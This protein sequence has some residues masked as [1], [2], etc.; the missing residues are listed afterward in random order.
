[1][2]M[3]L[4]FYR[5]F[6]TLISSN[7]PNYIHEDYT[8][9][10]SPSDLSETKKYLD[11]FNIE[12]NVIQN[13]SLALSI[14][15]FPSKLFWNDEQFLKRTIDTAS[16][17]NDILILN[18]DSEKPTKLYSK[19]ETFI[20]FNIDSENYFF[21][22]SHSYL[23]FLDVLFEENEKHNDV[24]HFVDDYSKANGRAIFTS[25]KDFGKLIVRF[26]SGVLLLNENENYSIHVNNFIDC[27]A[28][29]NKH[30]PKFLK[31]E[32]FNFL[33]KE[34]ESDRITI[35]FEKFNE[36]II[37]AKLNFEV[38]LNDL[39][40]ESLKKD[41][42]DYK[43][44]YFN[45]LNDFLNSLTNKII[46]LP[47]TISAVLFGMSKATE[48]NISLTMLI[49]ALFITCFYLFGIL[50]INME[51]LKNIEETFTRDYKQFSKSSFFIKFPS[52]EHYF[53]NV[54]LR[55]E[56]KIEKLKSFTKLFFW[57]T[58]FSHCALI[59]Y[60]FSFI[61]S[62]TLP[63]IAIICIMSFLLTALIYQYYIISE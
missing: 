29:E 6:T 27:F 37:T 43:Q 47:V 60:C 41:Y 49:I 52:E 23:K 42:N 19:G 20:D 13:I 10:I 58:S 12:N 21:T 46:A 7:S 57:I 31:N 33:A 28:K 59:T 30:L 53:L 45:Q 63:L 3:D 44:K 2:E 8:I 36:I 39:S 24:F 55:I 48:S 40:L 56:S 38:Y 35:L 18:I 15:S 17:K 14:A 26:N 34:K 50:R 5:D 61:F 25:A 16:F 51:D 32:F 1:M 9:V 22:N 62:F 4:N 54:K 11:Q